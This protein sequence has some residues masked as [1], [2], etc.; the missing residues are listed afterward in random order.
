MESSRGR[1]VGSGIFSSSPSSS[2]E[3]E[4][5]IRTKVGTNDKYGSQ[6]KYGRNVELGSHDKIF[7]SNLTS[8]LIIISL[9]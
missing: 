9:E 8:L 3:E 2:S 7:S 5:I 4:T 1:C 6:A